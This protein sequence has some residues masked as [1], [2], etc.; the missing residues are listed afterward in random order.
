MFPKA[1]FL[2]RSTLIVYTHRLALVGRVLL[3]FPRMVLTF[4]TN[5]AVSRFVRPSAKITRER[6]RHVKVCVREVSLQRPRS[7]ERFFAKFTVGVARSSRASFGVADS[8]KIRAALF[9]LLRQCTTAG[10][11]PRH[12]LVVHV[13]VLL[14]EKTVV[15]FVMGINL[16]REGFR[17]ELDLHVTVNVV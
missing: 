14:F 6:L 11:S 10:T 15:E 12:L 17:F 16:G 9:R 8:L 7:G 13:V 4:V 2:N 3:S 1:E 5:Q